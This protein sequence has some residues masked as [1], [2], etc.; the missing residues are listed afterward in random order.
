[1]DNKIKNELSFLIKEAKKYRS[2]EEFIK[3]RYSL[4]I[5][6]INTVEK[7]EAVFERQV[8]FNKILRKLWK[9]KKIKLSKWSKNI[10]EDIPKLK[11]AGITNLVDFYNLVKEL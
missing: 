10:K 7:L 8:N 3:N 2:A 6:K 5:K 1:M 11:R 4:P 9:T